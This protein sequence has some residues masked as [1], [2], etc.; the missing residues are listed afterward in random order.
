VTLGARAEIAYIHHDSNNQTGWTARLSGNASYT[1]LPNDRLNVVA[2]YVREDRK[3]GGLS[4][5]QIAVSTEWEHAFE[6]GFIGSLGGEASYRLYES[7]MVFTSEKQENI[8]AK[9]IIGVS[10]RDFMIGK[11]RPELAYTFT[12][13][14]SNDAFSDFTAHDVSVQAKAAF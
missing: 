11:L 7:N 9:G 2:S 3:R 8:Q 5:N 12:K 1:I 13:Q 10:H 4:Y 6:S 14:W